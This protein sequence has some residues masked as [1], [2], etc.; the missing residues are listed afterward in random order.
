MKRASL[1]SHFVAAIIIS[2]I[3]LLIYVSVQQS[4]R[5]SA[6][7]PQIQLARDIS[8]A[9]S[10]RKSTINLIPH[11]TID[12][13]QSLG[14]FTEIFDESGKPLQSTGFL[15]GGFP[16]PPAGVFNYTNTNI[17][18]VLTWQPASEVRLAM[19]LEK[20][21]EPGKGFVAVGRSLKEIEIRESNLLRMVE[22]VWF[23]CMVFL[24]IHLLLQ[25]YINRKQVAISNLKFK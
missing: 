5:A 14:V 8:N 1:L 19:V 18:D 10:S 20:I 15:N 21:N 23:T 16:K 4:F 25:N 6:N 22:I 12:L 24:L 7:D 17:E 2:A 3:I 9:I 13:V 11:Y